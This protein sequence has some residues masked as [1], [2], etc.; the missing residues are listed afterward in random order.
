MTQRVL[1]F[2]LATKCGVAF[3]DVTGSPRFLTEVLGNASEGHPAR[4]SQTLHLTQILIKRHKPT[5]IALEK[6]LAAGPVGGQERVQIAMGMRACVMGVARMR[7]VRV[8]EYP[9]ATVRK[10]FIGH[11]GLPG[12]E[13]KAAVMARCRALGWDVEDDNQGDACAVWDYARMKLFKIATPPTGDLFAQYGID[14]HERSAGN[15][16]A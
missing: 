10:H 16:R 12:K 13:A 2:D 9:I 7:N 11:G 8:S 14:T 3:G 4:F 6:A 5:V 15:K 1:A